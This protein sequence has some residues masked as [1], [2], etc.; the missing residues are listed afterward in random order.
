MPIRRD[1][2]F[3]GCQAAVFCWHH[4]DRCR[5]LWSAARAMARPG[6]LLGLHYAAMK[7]LFAFLSLVLAIAFVLPLA[8]CNSDRA[9]AWRKLD[10]AMQQ[11]AKKAYELRCANCHGDAGR[12]DGPEAKKCNPKPRSFVSEKWQKAISDDDIEVSIV[13]GGAAI[14]KS[15]VM[16]PNAD[17]QDKP[18]LVAAMRAYVRRLGVTTE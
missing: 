8:A 12:G 1:T 18:E 10:K 17:L 16:P 9:S 6:D 14:K 4:A 3:C 15:V 5:R 2:E 7:S 13:G 11:R